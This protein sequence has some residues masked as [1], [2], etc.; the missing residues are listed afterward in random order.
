MVLGR[1]RLLWLGLAGGA[2]V[3]AGGATMAA[4]S[5]ELARAEARLKGRS[6]LARSRFGPI[7]YAVAGEGPP[8]L[9]IHGTGGGFDQGL[10]LGSPLSLRW[11]VIA[12]SRFGYLESPYP[13][14]PSSENQADAFADLLDELG[15]ERAPIIGASAGALSAIQFAIRHPD[16]C[17]ALVAL[18]PA[19]YAPGR[20]PVDPPNALAQAIIEHALRSDLLFWLGLSLNEDA[21]IGALLATDPALVKAAEPAERARVRS[22]LRNILPVSARAKGL[23][24]DARLAYNPAPIALEVIRV[25]T[26]ALSLEDDRFQTLAAAKHI[27]ATVPGAKLVSYPTGG[28]VWVGR[29]EEA[30]SAIERFLS[31][32]G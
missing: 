9:S 1:R 15:I 14:D 17:S 28:H 26:L 19:V 23:M 29:R 12:P 8:L 4:F 24:N 2:A 25:P 5:S 18:V 32:T 20:P 21:M 22:I 7:E 10:D 3:L 30:Y 6:Q 13:D 31:E 27:A 16:R 11:R